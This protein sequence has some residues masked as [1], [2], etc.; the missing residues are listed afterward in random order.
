MQREID[1]N[2]HEELTL[3]ERAALTFWGA[4]GWCSACR[5]ADVPVAHI[6]PTSR[7]IHVALCR[8]CVSGLHLALSAE[9]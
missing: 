9:A 3:D 5:T 1:H 6:G 4:T 2:S 8:A 7:R